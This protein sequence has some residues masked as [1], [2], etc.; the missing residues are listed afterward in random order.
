MKKMNNIDIMAVL[1][2]V[3]I[4]FIIAFAYKM[5]KQ[6][7]LITKDEDRKEAEDLAQDIESYSQAGQSPS[8]T[9]SYYNSLA[10]KLYNADGYFN[11][12]EDAIQDVAKKMKKD[13]DI[14]KLESAMVSG[15][16]G[17]DLS[18]YLADVFNSWEIENYW[19]AHLRANGVT[20]MF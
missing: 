7:G 4:A 1:K 3:G 16:Y 13:I 15:Q 9:D 17:A 6:F 11:D 14:L 19:N 5:A 10:T 20:I 8:Y 12:D 2:W 18:T